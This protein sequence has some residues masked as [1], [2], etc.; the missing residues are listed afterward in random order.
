MDI[1]AVFVHK[2]SLENDFRDMK[3]K[4][5]DKSGMKY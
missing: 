3:Y 5:A 2:N 4:F 1:F